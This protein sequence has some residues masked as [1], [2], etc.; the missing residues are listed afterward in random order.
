MVATQS[1]TSIAIARAAILIAVAARTASAVAFVAVGPAHHGGG[2]GFVLIDA[3]SQE[4]DHVVDRPIWRSISATASC[5]A[6]MFMS[7]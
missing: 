2:R 4:A 5:G 1:R 3:N 6:S 7:V